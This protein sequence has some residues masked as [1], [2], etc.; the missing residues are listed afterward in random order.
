MDILGY[1]SYGW[2]PS[3]LYLVLLLV[4]SFKAKS[5]VESGLSSALVQ[6]AIFVILVIHGVQLHDSVFTPQGFVFGFAQDLSLIAW[7]GLAFYWFQ[8]WFLP[9]SS[10]RWMSLMFALICAF[11]PTVFPGTLLSPK[12]VSDPWFK[13]HFVVATVSV[14]LLSLA[15][16]HAMLMSVQDRALHRQLAIIP[17]GRLAHWLEDLPPL[18]TMESLLFNLLYVGFALLSLTVFSGL[19]F[20]QTLFGKPL[21]FDHKTIFAL[22]SWFLFAGLLIARWRVGLRGRAAIRWVLSAYTALLLAYVGSRFVVEVI[23]QRA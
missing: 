8:S 3:A 14:G 15:A 13:G 2:L 12:A 7:V 23:L 9:I 21:M 18:M 22:V 11:L 6:A 5:G 10:L 16:M 1:S 19:L 17:N 20:S 4:L